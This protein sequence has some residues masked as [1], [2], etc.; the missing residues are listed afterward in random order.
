VAADKVLNERLNAVFAADANDA[1]CQWASSGDYAPSPDLEHIQATVLT[2]NSADNE[3]NPPE[4]GI[5]EREL[6]RIKNARLVAIPASEDTRGHITT[7]FAKFWKQQVEELLLTTPQNGS[8][9]ART[10]SWRSRRR[11]RMSALWP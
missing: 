3:R 1:L 9:R 6:K 7:N 10:S 5:M 2:I 8:V 4:T 11:M